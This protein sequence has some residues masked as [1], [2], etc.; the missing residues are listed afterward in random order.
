M[1]DWTALSLRNHYSETHFAAKRDLETTPKLDLL[2][3][4]VMLKVVECAG[5]APDCGG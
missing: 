2:P 3:R 4:P 1:E 5:M